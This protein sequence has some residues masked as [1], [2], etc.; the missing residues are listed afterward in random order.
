MLYPNAARDSICWAQ[1]GSHL[2]VQSVQT[3]F[4]QGG[5]HTHTPSTAVRP[6]HDRANKGIKEKA[7]V[8][9]TSNNSN[10]AA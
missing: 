3:F 7:L 2:L 8:E 10:T 1:L 9:T 5:S 4:T 6:L